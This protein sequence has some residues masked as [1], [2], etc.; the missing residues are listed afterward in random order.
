MQLKQVFMNLLV[1][2]HQAIE[3]RGDRY[4]VDQK[5][6]IR[7]ETEGVGSEV[8][9]RIADTGIGVAPDVLARIFEPFFTTKPVGSGTG[10]GLSTCFNIV[11]RHGGRI[12]VESEE[13]VGSVFEVWLPITAPRVDSPTPEVETSA[14]TEEA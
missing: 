3:A 7:I 4:E 1:N 13:G 11:E 9:V 6:I 12:T 2:A 10:L 5:G 8:C 14:A